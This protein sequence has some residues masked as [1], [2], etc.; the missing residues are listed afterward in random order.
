MRSAAGARCAALR[1]SADRRCFRLLRHGGGDCAIHVHRGAKRKE[2]AGAVS[3]SDAR[4]GE[5][6]GRVV[7]VSA[8]DRR[9]Q[10]VSGTARIADGSAG[11]ED[12]IDRRGLPAFRDD[13]RGAES[14]D[15][16]AERGGSGG[17][18]PA[19]GGY[20]FLQASAARCEPDIGSKIYGGEEEIRPSKMLGGIVAE[21]YFQSAD[22]R[23]IVKEL[24]AL[25]NLPRRGR[26]SR[27]GATGS[28]IFCGI[29][30]PGILRKKT[31]IYFIS[32]LRFSARFLR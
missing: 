28:A 23:Q 26:W 1:R 31:S 4:W 25:R 24:V 30:W 14:G 27:S 21:S 6:A 12:G 8:S 2:R 7:T 20:V 18:A 22:S 32:A 19:F 10:F 13:L 9:R 11:G 15:R 3:G 5:I 29:F 16:G 17:A